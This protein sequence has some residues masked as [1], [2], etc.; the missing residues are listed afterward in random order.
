MIAGLLLLAI[1]T[2]PLHNVGRLSLLE[3]DIPKPVATH[4]IRLE[5]QDQLLR[6]GSSMLIA[7][8][9]FMTIDGLRKGY[10]ETNPLLGSHPA[11]GKANLLIGAGLLGNAFLV[12]KIRD[13]ELRRGIWVAMLL[14][15]TGA[16]HTNMQ[17][18]LHLNFRL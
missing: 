10:R 16:L 3:K 14:L 5:L 1:V 6:V 12:P 9:W 2:G 7:T 18:G 13:P 8:D 11:L 17:T 4:A 15:E